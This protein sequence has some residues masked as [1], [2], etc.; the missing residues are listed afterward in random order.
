MLYSQITQSQHSLAG[1]QQEHLKKLSLW[2]HYYAENRHKALGLLL[3]KCHALQNPVTLLKGISIS[4]HYYPESNLRLMGDIDILV[5]GQDLEKVESILSDLGYLRESPMSA[6]FYDTHHHTMPFHHPDSDIWI[7]VH[8]RLFREDDPYSQGDV[9]KLT[10][11]ENEKR[12]SMFG[13]HQVSRLSPELQLVYIAAHWAKDFK[14][15]GS[16][17]ACADSLYL[18]RQEA[19]SMDWNKIRN[20]LRNDPQLAIAMYSLFASMRDWKIMDLSDELLAWIETTHP[21]VKGLRQLLLEKILVRFYL[22]QPRFGRILSPNNM[23]VIWNTLM[24]PEQSLIAVRILVNVLFPPTHPD[25][26]KPAFLFKRLT[27][28]LRK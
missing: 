25:R 12:D 7:E 16:L 13:E 14:P 27:S 2:S 20:W 5:T 22:Q 11:I 1:K 23:I 18:L 17:N 21:S 4:T 3:Q 24:T 10:T 19:S 15:K 9:F 8:T 26:F 28:L 6:S